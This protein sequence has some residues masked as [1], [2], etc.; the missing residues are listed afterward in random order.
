[1]CLWGGRIG[2]CRISRNPEVQLI[3]EPTDN[4]KGSDISIYIITFTDPCGHSGRVKSR[5]YI[6]WSFE[7]NESSSHN[8][9][10]WFNIFSVI[11][12]VFTMKVEGSISPGGKM[13]V[14]GH[15]PGQT[16]PAHLRQ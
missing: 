6:R 7:H 2:K 15:P 11:S 12:R 8:T 14:A 13:F 3:K 4:S 10:H 16:N 9:P 1:M 5:Y